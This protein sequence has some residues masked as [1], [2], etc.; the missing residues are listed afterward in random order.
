M[1]T[2]LTSICLVLVLLCALGI[3]DVRAQNIEVP[4][5]NLTRID[6]I[7]ENQ[8]KG[9]GIVVGLNGTGDGGLNFVNRSIANALKELGIRIQNP[10]EAQLD[11]IAA[12]AL[13]A[14]LPPFRKPGDKI[15]VRLSSIGNA[16]DLSGGVLM[17]TP[18]KAANGKVYAVAQGPITKGGDGDNRHLTTVRIPNGAIVER[19]VPF[20][21][22]SR[23]NYI[24]LQLK[25]PDF[26]TANRI[27]EAINRKFQQII[28]KPKNSST[29]KVKLI[30]KHHGKTIDHPTEFITMINHLKVV[31][32]EQAQ[33]IVNER[34]GTVLMGGDIKV[35]PVS[36]SHGNLTLQVQG[37]EEETQGESVVL[38]KATT[39]R[40]VV[41]SLNAVGASTDSVIAI[42]EAMDKA[43]SL[44]APLEVM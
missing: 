42:L 33:V 32:G 17:Q 16:E 23:R 7:R 19:E 1:K 37:N 41:D 8:L 5:K 6:G 39:I 22:V 27:S 44:N 11:N 14:T 4:V 36:I 40:Q 10:S 9:F 29:I 28:A 34:T 26:T 31:P 35:R 13:T 20:K 18:L 15:D 25:N 30:N 3:Q 38:P 43:G 21:F 12:V 24:T 2:K